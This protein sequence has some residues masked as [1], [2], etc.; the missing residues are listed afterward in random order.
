MPA[1]ASSTPDDRG[2]DGSRAWASRGEPV[3]SPSAQWLAIRPQRLRRRRP[4]PVGSTRKRPRAHSCRAAGA[5]GLVVGLK[6]RQR[7]FVVGPVE[8]PTRPLTREI[9]QLFL[10]RF[11]GQG[12]ISVAPSCAPGPSG[13]GKLTSTPNTTFEATVVAE[14]PQ[15]LF[16]LDSEEGP[17]TAGFSEEAKRLGV[18]IRTGQRVLVTR[19]SL[20][21]GRGMIIGLAD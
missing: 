6:G 15:Q 2:R 11:S 5:E 10:A 1:R 14:L 17:F 9:P 4:A 3:G 12:W 8:R 19:A 18:S 7:P 16:R 13:S 20:D 21:P